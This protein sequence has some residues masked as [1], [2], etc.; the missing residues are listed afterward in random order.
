LAKYKKKFDTSQY[1]RLLDQ[2]PGLLHED[3]M[4]LL[5]DY[6]Y[7]PI[8]IRDKVLQANAKSVLKQIGI[9]KQYTEDEPRSQIGEIRGPRDGAR[10]H[11]SGGLIRDQNY[12]DNFSTSTSILFVEDDMSECVG[13]GD[14]PANSLAFPKAIES[15]FDSIAL[16]KGTRVVIYPQQKFQGSPLL[17]LVGPCII[18]NVEYRNDFPAECYN[19]LNIEFQDLRFRSVFPPSVRKLSSSNMNEWNSGSVKISTVGS[20]DEDD[21]A[22]L[23]EQF[24]KYEAA[25]EKLANLKLNNQ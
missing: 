6:Q 8:N 9:I 24:V 13:E 5:F 7:T 16:D 12:S 22:E 2:N 14:Y 23:N 21:E 1:Q 17:D 10:V 4:D 25:S 11:F 15:S 20:D 18:W 19:F 3:I